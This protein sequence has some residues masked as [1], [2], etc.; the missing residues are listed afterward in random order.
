MSQSVYYQCQRCTNCCRWPGFVRIDEQE[1][2]A[3]AEFM[4]LKEHDFIQIYTRLRPNREGLALID[5]PT[6]ECYFLEGNDCVLQ[7]VKPQQ[8]RDFPNKWN[9]PGWRQ[10]CEAIEVQEP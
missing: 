3:I 1:I 4:G 2:A 6:G 7:A 10:V 5:K 8:C 9:F